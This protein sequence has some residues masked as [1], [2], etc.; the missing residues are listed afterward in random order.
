MKYVIC[1]LLLVL[2]AAHQDFWNWRRIEPL[3]FGFIPIGLAHHIGISIG[4]VVLWS[5]AARFMWVD[6]SES[7]GAQGADESRAAS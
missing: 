3:V 5:L 6:E 2:I 1:G 7:L 4:A